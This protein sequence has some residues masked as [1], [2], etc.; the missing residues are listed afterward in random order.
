MNVSSLGKVVHLY[1]FSVNLSSEREK[2]TKKVGESRSSSVAA[3]VRLFA[4]LRANIG[5]L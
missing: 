2:R 3:N 4:Y 1:T 5:F